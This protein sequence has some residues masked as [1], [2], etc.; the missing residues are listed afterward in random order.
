MA[1]IHE[2]LYR[3]GNLSSI[4]FAEYI[5]SLLSHLAYSY[6][7][8]SG[9]ITSR[10][11]IVGLSLNIDVAIPVGLIVNELVT[12]SFKHAFPGEATGEIFLELHKVDEGKYLLVVG[13]NGIGIPADFD[14]ERTTSLGLQLVQALAQQLNSQ[15]RQLEL[16]INSAQKEID[17]LSGNIND[18]EQEIGVV[19]ENLEAAKQ[20]MDNQNTSL[21]ERLRAMYKNGDVSMI[22]IL[23][24]SDDITDFM[25]NMDMVQKIFDNDVEVLKTLQEQHDKIRERLHWWI[26]RLLILLALAE[27]TAIWIVRN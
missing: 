18:T 25:S 20:D 4:D 15:I 5:N 24:G 16:Q 12:N 19:K 23:L 22:Q 1:L 8:N 2:R 7:G 3:S 9:R 11:D 6:G 17:N 13:D 14:L 27:V 21:K 10:S 26:F